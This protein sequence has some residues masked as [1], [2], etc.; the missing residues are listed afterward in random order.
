MKKAKTTLGVV[1]ALFLVSGALLL[2]HT[3]L[4][5]SYS[6]PAW[7]AGLVL[8]AMGMAGLITLAVLEQS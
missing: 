5:E 3:F 2:L 7:N 8:C 4:E 1:S 6:R